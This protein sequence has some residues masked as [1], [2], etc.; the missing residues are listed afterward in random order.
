MRQRAPE[1]G[2]RFQFI[3]DTVS[4]LRK[5]AWPTRRETLYLT[6]VVI[7]VSLL[8]GVFLGAIDFGFSQLSELFLGG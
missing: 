1:R 3:R 4:E 7:I 5:V 2:S 6:T 8:I